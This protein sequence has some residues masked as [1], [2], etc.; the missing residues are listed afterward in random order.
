MTVQ[1]ECE[2]L[3]FGDHDTAVYIVLKRKDRGVGKS[4][5]IGSADKGLDVFEYTV[6]DLGGKTVAR[7]VKGR[8]IGVG[9][10]EFSVD[11]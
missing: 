2:R 7:P 1:V 6:G 10:D 3:S 11:A 9:G 8:G 4:D 5:K